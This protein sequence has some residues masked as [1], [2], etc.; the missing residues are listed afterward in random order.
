MRAGR[1]IDAARLFLE[2]A[3]SVRFVV[4]P[5]IPVLRSTAPPSSFLLAPKDGNG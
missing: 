3:S 5:L 1:E 2:F 4:L